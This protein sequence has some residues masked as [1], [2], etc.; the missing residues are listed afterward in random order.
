M[1]KQLLIIQ[2]AAITL[3]A[4]PYLSMPLKVGASI[5][6]A[7]DTAEA[8]TTQYTCP[9]HPHYISSDPNGTC[10]IC[11]MDLVAV[12]GGAAQN[13]GDGISVAA[14]MI[15]TMGIR[16]VPAADVD[17]GKSLRA[18]GIVEPNQRLESVAVSRVEGWIE[19]LSVRARG[20]SVGPGA[21]LYQVYSPDLIAAQR[22]FLNALQIGNEDRIAA[23]RQRLRSLGMQTSVIDRLVQNRSVIERTPVFAEA[24][25]IVEELN[26]REGDYINPGT[27]IMRLQSYSNVWVMASVPETDLPLINAGMPVR[28][29]FPSAPQAPA[30]GVVDY[31]YPTID[32]RTRTAQLRIE[33]D[34]TSGV[35][36]PWAY[37]DIAMNLGG[38]P[39]LSV[40]TEA[41]LRDSRG[42]HVIISLGE[43]RF[44]GR[45]VETGINA[46]G[47]TE[48]LSGLEPGE[49]VVA[50][51]QF[52]LDSE[53]NLR[54]GFAKLSSPAEFGPD[55]PLSGLPIDGATLAEI[56][57]FTDMALYFHEA[58]T[59]RYRIDPFFAD[60]ALALGKSLR[61]RFAETQL[62]PILEEAESALI[63]AKEARQ[64]PELQTQLARLVKALEPWLLTGAP[65][66]YRDAGITLFKED[67]TG[68]PWIQQGQRPRNPYGDAGAEAI[69]WPDPMQGMAMDNAAAG[70]AIDPHAGHR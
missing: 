59:E 13:D 41:V 9:M 47:R 15:Q 26:V 14:E 30:D 8:A 61:A 69:A 51:G 16:S 33:V 10:P 3:S 22:D 70:S 4:Q 12:A 39:R 35:L 32:P 21:L 37:A 54:E 20:D 50:S 44:A 40:P 7:Q 60:P 29:D 38:Q 1:R 68:R 43:G 63:A 42:T 5:A 28:L 6:L 45:A 53:M 66:H 49:Q 46:D 58:L 56:D 24:G 55:T 64:G 52:L 19:D 65:I 25:G 27:P 11:G 2:V 67:G 57:H 18:F 34:N 17:M 31:I 36:L 62:V 48:I 23:V